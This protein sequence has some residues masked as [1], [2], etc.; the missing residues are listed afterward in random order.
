MLLSLHF[1]VEGAVLDIFTGL[2]KICMYINGSMLVNVKMMFI[3][4]N[5]L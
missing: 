3:L 5:F 4:R 2:V 1:F